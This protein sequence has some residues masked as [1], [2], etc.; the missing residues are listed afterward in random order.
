MTNDTKLTEIPEHHR[1]ATAR[2][3]DRAAS[4]A[5]I[6]W[7][8]TGQEITQLF[9]PADVARIVVEE[10]VPEVLISREIAELERDIAELRLVRAL[11][12]IK[13]LEAE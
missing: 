13:E 2:I 3:A 4:H 6:V 9:R 5:E 10:L 12:R 1:I 11:A 7:G 8:P